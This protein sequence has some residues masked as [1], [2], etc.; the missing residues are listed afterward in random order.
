[1]RTVFLRVLDADDK[2]SAIRSACVA[3]AGGPERTR[4]E[5]DPSLFG[6]ISGSPFCYWVS[7]G[8]RQLFRRLNLLNQGIG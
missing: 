2:S 5:L 7:D 6:L 3:A 4:M 1:M 8:V